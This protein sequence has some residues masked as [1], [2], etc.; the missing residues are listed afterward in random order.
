MCYIKPSLLFAEALKNKI[1]VP[2]SS[3]HRWHTLCFSV[4]A[5]LSLLKN[6]CGP[7]T[8]LWSKEVCSTPTEPWAQQRSILYVKRSVTRWKGT[9]SASL[10]PKVERTTTHWLKI[11]VKKIHKK[12][13]NSWLVLFSS[14]WQKSGYTYAKKIQKFHCPILLTWI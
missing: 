11:Q 10:C 7:K 6:S 14:I 1:M 12:K 8:G 5:P 3:R 13:T 2:W 4:Q 9:K